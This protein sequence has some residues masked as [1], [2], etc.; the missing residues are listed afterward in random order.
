MRVN[1][2]FGRGLKIF[3]EGYNGPFSFENVSTTWAEA[4]FIAT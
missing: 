1:F 3:A 4:I 2:L